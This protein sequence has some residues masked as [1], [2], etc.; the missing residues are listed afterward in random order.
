VTVLLWLLGAVVVP[1]A[2]GELTDLFPWLAKRLIRWATRRLPEQER[3]RWEEEWLG[4]L[5]ERPGKLLKLLWALPLLWGAGK[6]GRL[7]GAPPLSEVLRARIRALWQWL[8]QRL[9]LRPKAPSEVM[10]IEPKP[11]TMNVELQPP[12][13][14]TGIGANRKT[15]ML[16]DWRMLADELQ[17]RSG[18]WWPVWSAAQSFASQQDF[19]K[20]MTDQAR[21]SEEYR[22]KQ[23][24]AFEDT[25][26]RLDEEWQRIRRPP[27]AAR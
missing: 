19:E 11:V 16:A 18:T 6:M 25:L 20:W 8:M 21:E 14:V 24:R 22:A 27:G 4:E 9:R 15:W 23:R 5:E 3:P 2:L 26:A 12:V 7:L 1:L 10:V 13:V 17:T